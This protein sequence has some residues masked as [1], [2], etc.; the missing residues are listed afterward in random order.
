MQRLYLE[1]YIRLSIYFNKYRIPSARF[2]NWDYS[3]NGAYF[4]TI[5]TGGREH[6]FGKIENELVHLSDIGVIASTFLY[7]IPIHFTFAEIDAFVVMPNHIHAL[8]IINQTSLRQLETIHATSRS[9]EIDSVKNE[10]M[11]TISPKSGSIST[12]IRSYKSAV[13]KKARKTNPEFY[14][15]T[16]FHDH[17]VRNDASYNKI[18]KYIIDNPLLWNKDKFYSP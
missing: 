7:Q 11:S 14:W 3:A 1:N 5:C 10:E 9:T 4:I 18:R 13:S 2:P 12:I 8:I 17:I 16:R 15:Q 6:Y